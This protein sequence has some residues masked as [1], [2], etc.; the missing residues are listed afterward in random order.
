MSIL[1]TDLKETKR[2]E[3]RKKDFVLYKIN[4]CKSRIKSLIK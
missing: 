4:F 3:E 1:I 2:K